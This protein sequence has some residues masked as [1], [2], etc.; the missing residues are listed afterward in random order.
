MCT[1]YFQVLFLTQYLF[2]LVLVSGFSA[3]LTASLVVTGD[4]PLIETLEDV[5]EYGL[6]LYI[7]GIK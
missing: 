5:K 4:S 1:I 2:C 6:N 3:R 7:P